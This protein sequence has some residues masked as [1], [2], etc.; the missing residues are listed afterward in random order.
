M[1]HP[2][3]TYKHIFENSIDAQIVVNIDTEEILEVNKATKRILGYSEKDLLGKEFSTLSSTSEDEVKKISDNY[4]LDSVFKYEFVN[5]K[6]ENIIC[7]LTVTIVPW[8]EDNALLFSI[9]DIRDRLKYEKRL[10]QV[11]QQLEELSTTD[12]LTKLYNRRGLR[13][14]IEHEVIRFERNNEA[15]VLIISDIDDLKTINDTYGHDAGDFL[16]VELSK[17]MRETIRKQD[18]IGRWGGD[19]FLFLLPQT[20]LSG[21]ECLAKKIRQKINDLKISFKERKL[22]ATMTFGVSVFQ[23]NDTLED[24]FKRSDLALYR[25]KKMGKNSVVLQI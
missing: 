15:F 10:K 12:P 6:G 17:V 20:D 19:E 25:A 21:G 22:S 1:K 2:Y 16:I 11:M 8:H 7:E 4:V 9:R 13:N 5:N 18:F 24:C 3:Q 23:E 14:E